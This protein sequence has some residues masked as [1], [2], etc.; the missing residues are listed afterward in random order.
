MTDPS[1]PAGPLRKILLATDLSARGDRALNRAVQL[2]A[3]SGARLT[4]LHVF[5]RDPVAGREAAGAPSWKRPVDA[6]T[7]AKRRIH[8]GLRAEV[9][10]QLDGA[11]VRVEEGDAAQVI[12]EVAVEENADLVVTGIASE[13]PFAREP[14]LLGKTVEELVRRL[15]LPVLIVRNRAHSAYQH[16]LVATDFSEV[17]GHAV[18][19]ALQYFPSQPIHLL[20]AFEVPYGFLIADRPRHERYFAG[21][22]GDDMNAFLDSLALPEEQ[23]RRIEPLVEHGSADDLVGRYVRDLHADLVVL[24]THGRGKVLETLVGSTAKR[25]LS[26]L[27]CDALLVRR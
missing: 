26:S 22:L 11:A 8:H 25:I 3:G 19:V 23:R 24:G 12:Q 14:V 6:T 20:H 21:A 10:R 15:P 5:E 2:A 18:Q 1:F 9:G 27:P 4:I 17:S 13:R 7:L 16:V